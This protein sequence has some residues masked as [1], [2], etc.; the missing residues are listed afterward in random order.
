[1]DC[2]DCGRQDWQHQFCPYWNR[3]IEMIQQDPN[4]QTI[5]VRCWTSLFSAPSPAPVAAP[6][7]P[8]Y[9]PGPGATPQV[10]PT[11]Q[12]AAAPVPPP[13][14]PPNLRMNPGTFEAMNG[15]SPNPGMVKK[16]P[17][18]RKLDFSI[19]ISAITWVT[20]ASIVGIFF[21]LAIFLQVNPQIVIRQTDLPI[22]VVGVL[23]GGTVIALV[24]GI[25]VLKEW[26]NAA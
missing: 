10:P 24:K 15:F 11:P 19:V 8:V 22:Y 16:K 2:R 5:I 13:P 17:A 7:Q 21:L 1:M 3:P 23:A 6:V 20:V 12:P 14:P 18:K 9:G 4:Y 25:S 26:R